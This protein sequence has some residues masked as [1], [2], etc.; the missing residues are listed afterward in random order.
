MSE[1]FDWDEAVDQWQS[2]EPELPSI[3]RNMRW[4]SWRMKA[5]LALDI[6]GLMVLLPFAFFIFQSEESTSIKIWFSITCVLA[7]VGV[8]FDFYLRRE[9]WQ[10]PT[11]TKELL[12]HMIKREKAGVR[13]GQFAVVYLG[14]FLVILISWAVSVW[15]LEQERFEGEYALLSVVCGS[16]I[17]LVSI[18]MSMVYKK[19]KQKRLQQV[20]LELE[21]FLEAD[22]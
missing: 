12:N 9:L 10:Q 6:V 7:V 19:R 11:N 1:K 8:Y 13:I 3:K 15:F 18:I 17:M 16:V 21:K 2:H 14:I 5:V 22:K 4:L 20:E